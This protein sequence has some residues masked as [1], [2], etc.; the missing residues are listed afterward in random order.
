M[1]IT[2][3]SPEVAQPLRDQWTAQQ[4]RRVRELLTVREP[5]GPAPTEHLGIC[6]DGEP[7]AVVTC[8]L[9]GPSRYEVHLAIKK[10]VGASQLFPALCAIRDQ[11]VSELHAELVVWVPKRHPGLQRLVE[12]LEFEPSGVTLLQGHHHRLI[13]SHRFTYTEH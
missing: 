9:R 13:E 12:A 7:I 10:G 4:P 1:E 11:M 5:Q 8:E 3:L 6:N 2:H